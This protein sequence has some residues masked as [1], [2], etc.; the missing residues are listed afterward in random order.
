MAFDESEGSNAAFANW[1]EDRLRERD[2]S[3]RDLA[4]R[5]GIAHSSVNRALHPNPD[6]R[7][8]LKVVRAIA[9]TLGVPEDEA[10]RRAGLLPRLPGSS[11]DEQFLVFAHRQ[12]SAAGR[13]D[14]LVRFARFL[15]R[16]G[17]GQPG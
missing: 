7:L 12:L 11:Y 8:G 4:R 16:D 9:V 13:G 10:V 3:G 1:L 5:A 17:T 2:W 15:L 6:R 14:E